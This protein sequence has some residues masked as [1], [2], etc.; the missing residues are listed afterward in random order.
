[1]V[2]WMGGWMEGS[3]DI[4]NLF[5]HPCT[6]HPSTHAQS[7]AHMLVHRFDLNHSYVNSSMDPSIAI[8]PSM[9]R[10]TAKKCENHC[11]RNV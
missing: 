5:V 6:L 8:H 10:S 11:L 9:L 3:T 2:E 4:S 1:M 7:S